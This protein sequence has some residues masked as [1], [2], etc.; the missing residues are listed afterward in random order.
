MSYAACAPAQQILTN[1]AD[2]FAEHLKE[3]GLDQEV[4]DAF[5]SNVFLWLAVIIVLT[6]SGH[7][8]TS[9]DIKR[10]DWSHEKLIRMGVQ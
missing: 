4:I 8:I 7:K 9:R 1:M 2:N 5:E 10:N 6:T 3:K